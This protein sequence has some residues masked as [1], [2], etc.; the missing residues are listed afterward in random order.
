MRQAAGDV[1]RLGQIL[2]GR[3]PLSTRDNASTLSC[4]Q[5][6]RLAKVRFFTLPPSR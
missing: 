2:P 5:R 6:V 4:G 3:L 1:K